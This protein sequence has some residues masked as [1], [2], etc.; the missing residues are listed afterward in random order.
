MLADVNVR[1]GRSACIDFPDGTFGLFCL[2]N[3][4][5]I[6]YIFKHI[7]NR[8]GG[9]WAL[10]A[11]RH[12]GKVGVVARAP[13]LKVFQAQFGFYDSVVAAFSQVAALRAWGTH[14]NL[15]ADGQARVT[16]DEAAV[17][18]ALAHPE[19][20]LR[21]AV[22]SN[23]RFE[24]NP[25]SWRNVPDAPNQAHIKPSLGKSKTKAPAKPPARS[26]LD[27]TEAALRGVD[28]ERKREET[29]LRRRRDQLDAE[30]AGAQDTYVR[31]RRAAT[32]AVVEARKA[33]RRAGGA[34]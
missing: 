26:Q 14:Q 18:A 6:R 17:K 27:A 25:M 33:F 29:E 8:E 2:L 32:S 7:Q 9:A 31:R 28:D 3:N 30:I 15:F 21:R 20:P 34:E 5:A 11:H 23:D 12:R 10:S 4:P 22:G 13:R 19:T 16:S 1:R 24:L